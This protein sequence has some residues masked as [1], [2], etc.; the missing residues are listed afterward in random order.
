MVG[1]ATMHELFDEMKEQLE[2]LDRQE[3]LLQTQAQLAGRYAR[4]CE[5]LCA[6]IIARRAEIGEVVNKWVETC[7]LYQC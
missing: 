2:L 4:I 6:E 1:Q 3:A 7:Q 5:A